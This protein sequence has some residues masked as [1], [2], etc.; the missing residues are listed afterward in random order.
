MNKHPWC[1]LPS[2]GCTD[3]YFAQEALPKQQCCLTVA[4]KESG[5]GPVEC[6]VLE[7]HPVLP[8]RKAM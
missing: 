8:H 2:G 6:H 1:I 4:V 5:S 7:V 3:A